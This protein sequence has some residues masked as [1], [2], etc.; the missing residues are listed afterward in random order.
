MSVEVSQ[1]DVSFVAE[2]NRAC[3]PNGYVQGRLTFHGVKN[4]EEVRASLPPMEIEGT[5][6]QPEIIGVAK[7][8][9]S[10]YVVDL[11][12]RESYTIEIDCRSMIEL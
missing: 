9:K 12:M 1:E 6:W 11:F 2:L 10:R 7:L 5:A 4:M 8:D 3:N